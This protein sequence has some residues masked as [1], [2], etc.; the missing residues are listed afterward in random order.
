MPGMVDPKTGEAFDVP[1]DEIARATDEFGL[2]PSE[3]YATLQKY[4]SLASQAGAAGKLAADTATFG[5]TGFQD[6]TEGRQ[7]VEAFKEL[8]P[9]LG[10]VTEIAGAA[11]PGLIGG[12]LAG[13]GLRGLG[14]SARAAQI[15]STVAEEVSQAGALEA[16][17]AREEDRGI[18]L[19]NVVMGLPL[20]LGVSAAGR[21][22][23][24]AARRLR[25]SS[26][27]AEAMGE[28]VPATG[29]AAARA[30]VDL[31]G[32]TLEDLKAL[33]IEGEGDLARVEALKQ[34]KVFAQTGRVTSNDGAAGITIVNDAGEDVLRD[35]RHRLQA[36]QE[37][38]RSSVYGRYV[39]GATGKVLYEGEIPL[40][41]SA[42]GAA[43]EDSALAENNA[44]SRGRQTSTA[45]RS[46][47]AAGAGPDARPPLTED[48]VRRLAQ[49]RPAV[50]AQVEK[51]G[52]DAIE[53]T[54][55]GEAPTLDAVHN[56]GLKKADAAGRMLDADPER[57]L[58]FADEHIQGLEEFAQELDG[59][60][61]K[62]AA[63]NVRARIEEMGRAYTLVGEAPEELAIA[64]DQAKRTIGNLRTKYGAIKDTAAEALAESSQ[65]MYD[66]LRAGLE[67]GETFGK[68]WAEKQAGENGLWSGTKNGNGGIIRN[69]A[70]WQS[71]FTELAPGAAG[72][73]WRDTKT[74]PVFRMRGDIVQQAL[75]MTPRRF[76]EV[77][78]AW[79][80]WIKDV[81]EMSLLKTELG[82]KSVDATPIVKL[83][84][85][86]NDMKQTISELKTLREVEHRGAA[87]ISKAASEGPNAGLLEKGLEIAKQVPGAG[88][89]I[90]AGELAGIIRPKVAEPLREFTR[91]E[92]RA[93][94][95]AR[96]GAL[97]KAAPRART[98]VPRGTGGP[99]TGS[100]AQAL[101]IVEQG[102]RKVETGPLAGLAGL[103]AVVGASA[104][105]RRDE[106]PVTSTLAQISDDSRAITERAALGLV[107]K[108]SRPP[109]LEPLAVRFRGNAPSLQA[110]FQTKLA[111]LQTADTDPQAF[112]D[113]MADTF[114]VMAHAGHDDLFSRVVARVQIGT[115]YLLANAPPSV[116]IS[117]V[118]PDGIPPDSLAIMKW[119]SMY[120]AVFSPGDVVY[121]VA[122]GEATPTQIKTLREVHPDIYGQLRTGVLKQVAQAGPKIP[123]ETL[124]TLDVLF[125][126]PGAAGLSFSE[127]MQATM[128][129]AYAQKGSAGPKQSL[130]GESVIAPASATVGLQKGPSTLQA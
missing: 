87:Y 71:E 55:G 92:A 14:L 45:R 96:Q 56:I 15:G 90:K 75:N 49:D 22:A 81:E 25:G 67:D 28:A 95:A 113:G 47:G 44:L 124:R 68:F 93:A 98:D 88:R 70:I 117:M 27:A 115:Q 129:G 39:D 97:G 33:P 57:L 86:L 53:E 42:G 127:G 130:G 83:Q 46:V 58:D 114:G 9:T 76:N 48:E 103:G 125:D 54:V 41:A 23:G 79:N 101:G 111:E 43:L 60:G 21:L 84:Q 80:Q 66:K 40:K 37:L 7:Q 35:G 73:V 94:G 104:A 65:A 122:T 34:N 69:G 105:A 100:V 52:G 20:A 50:H 18:D 64:A 32:K 72:R 123:F 102:A 11:A 51:L 1:A 5:L 3:H 12:G 19:G 31:T 2:V 118:R 91:E 63:R 6:S 59:A 30:P 128:A 85:S 13:A 77:T 74:V 108:E 78:G 119:A 99:P 24:G 8:S 106:H 17:H 116:G 10:A 120:N 89:V 126:L 36:A 121:D 112:V 16:Q 109:K 110:A 61:Q 38:G 29:P 107:S 4:S 62:A 26:A 82:A